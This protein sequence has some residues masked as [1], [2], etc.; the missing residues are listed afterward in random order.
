MLTTKVSVT[1]W[2]NISATEFKTP[3]DGS[4]VFT[5]AQLDHPVMAPTDSIYKNG[6]QIPP[7]V[8]LSS[9]PN[10][11]FPNG[12]VLAFLL[13][14]PN[15]SIQTRQVWAT[16]NGN[17]TLGQP[18]RSPGNIDSY[19][20][21]YIL[22]GILSA[23]QNNSGPNTLERV[24]LG[25]VGTDM[26]ATLIFGD[27]FKAFLNSPP[28]P[29]TNITAAYTRVIRSAMKTLLSGTIATANVTGGYAKEQMVFTSSLG[30]VITSTILFT[31]LAITLVAAKF[32]KGR[33]AFTFVDVAAALA[34]SDVPQKCAEMTQFKAGREEMRVLKLVPSGD[35]GLNC[36]YQSVGC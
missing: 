26:M 9:I 2:V 32:R 22:S 31:L 18:R 3:M 17:L 10:L 8:N 16:G 14:S 4:T 34:N 6:E 30:Y 29:L 25:D 23:F 35:G 28:A 13:C 20:A 33:D 15:A 1:Q 12:N 19:Q 11:Q 7:T 24:G 5:I 21:N 27:N 36:T